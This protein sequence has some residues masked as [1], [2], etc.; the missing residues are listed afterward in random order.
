MKKRNRRSV[1]IA[2]TL[3]ALSACLMAD[4]CAKAVVRCPADV[5]ELG[6][7]L[8][9]AYL[10]GQTVRERVAATLK[11]KLT[12]LS[13]EGDIFFVPPD[14][15][16]I[17]IRSDWGTTLLD[18]KKAGSDFSL[19][20]GENGKDAG[21]LQSGLEWLKG[22][23][24][25][26]LFVGRPGLE[27]FFPPESLTI[28]CDGKQTRVQSP[29]CRAV[30]DRDLRNFSRIESLKEGW[31]YEVLSYKQYQDGIL[32]SRVRLSLPEGGSL[33]IEVINRSA[34]RPMTG[35]SVLK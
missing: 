17:E 27:G 35:A 10:P 1:R 26:R 11:K 8:Q 33:E 16:R 4:G 21:S 34:G 12:S 32:P 23:A 9:P 7:T 30:F 24:A 14:T 25:L 18:L 6:R 31:I 13:A 20:S 19:S 2:I 3:L 29:C 28:I 5:A 22:D 15:L